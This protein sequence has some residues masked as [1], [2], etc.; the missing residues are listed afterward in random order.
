MEIDLKITPTAK[1]VWDEK[2]KHDLHYNA[3]K[4]NFFVPIICKPHIKI[5]RKFFNRVEVTIEMVTE[6]DEIIATSGILVLGK[7]KHNFIMPGCL[8]Q[9]NQT[10]KP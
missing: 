5:R 4:E 10:I 3:D 8:Y 9:L 6:N 1:I 7:N 2:I